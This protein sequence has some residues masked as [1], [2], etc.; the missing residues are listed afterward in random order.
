MY[1][2][3]LVPLD[4]SSLSEQVLPYVRQLAVGLSIPVTVMTVVEP[5]VPTIGRDLNL[6]RHEHET[7]EHR[8]GRITEYLES[9]A[10]GLRSEGLD[11]SSATPSDPPAPAIVAEADREPETLIAMSGHGRSGLARWWLG[12]L[13]DQVLRLT[14]KPLLVVRSHESRAA[15]QG[16]NLRT[17][18]IPLDGS[19]LAEQILP[20][21]AATAAGLGLTVQLVSVVPPTVQYVSMAGAGEM[22]NSNLETMATQ[23]LDDAASYL[24]QVRE[25]LLSQGTNTVENHVLRGDPAGSIIDL[26][27]AT[28][29][30]LVAMTTRGRSGLGRW[31]LGSVA[32][33]VVRNS[34]DPVLLVRATDEG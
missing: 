13:T 19:L 17:M 30:K 26:A 7:E 4:G 34:G 25:R 5:S 8:S 11:V 32:D 16:D 18:V 2:R 6:H 22:Y 3:I 9:V 21:A 1:S 12:S 24:A 20:H 29:D 27:A 28:S 10:E 33:R 15:T 31:I 14:D 23:A